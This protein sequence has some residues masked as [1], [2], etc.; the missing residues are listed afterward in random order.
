MTNYKYKVVFMSDKKDLKVF[1]ESPLITSSETEENVHTIADIAGGI[2]ELIYG[3]DF[4]EKYEIYGELVAIAKKK[5]KKK[6]KK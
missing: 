1:V 6:S 5:K 2:A 3:E 4:R